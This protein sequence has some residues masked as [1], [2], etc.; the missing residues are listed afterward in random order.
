MNSQEGIVSVLV[1]AYFHGPRLETIISPIPKSS[2]NVTNII[3]ES[4]DLHF[5]SP[6][7][8]IVKSRAFVSKMF[9]KNIR[10]IMR[11]DIMKKK[12]NMMLFHL[13]FI[14]FSFVV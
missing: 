3:S 11:D 4:L 12:L 8:V 2:P 10:T 13:F 1:M 14:V 7:I 5:S 6:M 9:L